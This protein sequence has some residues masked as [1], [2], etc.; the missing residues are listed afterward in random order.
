MQLGGKLL[1][2]IALH[3]RIN[4]EALLCGD[5]KGWHT[6]ALSIPLD[7]IRPGPY[8]YPPP[9]ETRFGTSQLDAPASQPASRS[10]AQRS[11]VPV[12]EILAMPQAE[13]VLVFDACH[14]GVI[15]RTVLTVELLMGVGAM[16]VT[17]DILGWLSLLAII[18]GAALP[19][20]LLW[21]VVACACK[22]PLQKLSRTGQWASGM[23]LGALAGLYGC[24]LLVWVGFINNAP[25]AASAVS[26]AL[27]AA[28]LVA[29]LI[30]RAQQRAPASAAARLSELQSRIRPHFLFNTLN[31]AIALVRAEPAKAEML[32]EDLSE[33]F[34][35]ALVDQ[36]D[37]V[38]LS[39]EIEL[40]KRYLAIEEVRFGNRLR[41]DWAIDPAT[42][43]AKLPPLLLQPLVENAVKHGVEPSAS[44]A[45][46]KIS[47]QKRGGVIVIKITNTA[48]GGQGQAGHGVALQNVQDRLRLL[49]D[50]QASFRCTWVDGVYQVRMEIPA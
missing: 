12:Q 16:F 28:G 41:V 23:A 40:A 32:L 24:A 9:M 47:A 5:G 49:H 18:T 22:K 30:W 7:F 6:A 26:G 38:T 36:G 34:R 15:L 35:S 19:A 29:A 42:L 3:E 45:D 27:I 1:P 11:V 20:A 31:S 8:T 37:A 48:P 33:L 25:W 2:E 44:G 46:V 43:Q 10:R 50:V 13:P 39:Q 21:L 17:H 14:V 4:A